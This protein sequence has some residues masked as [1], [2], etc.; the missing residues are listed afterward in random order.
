MLASQHWHTQLPDPQGRPQKPHRHVCSECPPPQPFPSPGRPLGSGF[1]GCG[2]AVSVKESVGLEGSQSLLPGRVQEGVHD[3]WL[4]FTN[5][6]VPVCSPA[7]WTQTC[8]TK[9]RSRCQCS[10]FKPGVPELLHLPEAPA[11]DQR[12]Q[13]LG[14]STAHLLSNLADNDGD[15][16]GP[17]C[18]TPASAAAGLKPPLCFLPGVCKTSYLTSPKLICMALRSPESIETPVQK[19]SRYQSAAR[20]TAGPVWRSALAVIHGCSPPR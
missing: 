19:S 8:P 18:P 16:T 2:S 12:L 13:S 14:P 3:L 15:L 17:L 1:Q 9:P 10:T 5:N 20:S 11:S 4:G 7:R 6:A